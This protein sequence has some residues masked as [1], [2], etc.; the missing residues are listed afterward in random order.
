M[1][2]SFSGPISLLLSIR[3][4]TKMSTLR[5]LQPRELPITRELSIEETY[6]LASI[7]RRKSNSGSSKADLRQRLGTAQLLGALENAI[8][9]SPPPSPQQSS[10][11][12]IKSSHHIAWAELETPARQSQTEVDEYGFAYG[13]EYDDDSDDSLSLC[14][15]QSRNV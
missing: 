10:L 5:R 6:S 9:N 3:N 1:L 14:R 11:K 8:R 15:T 12:P 7:A 4:M 2:D 13:D